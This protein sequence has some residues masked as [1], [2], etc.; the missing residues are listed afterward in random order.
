[1]RDHG[2]RMDLEEHTL[3]DNLEQTCSV[4]GARLTDAEIEA[5]R[6][7]GGPFLCSVHT[8]EALPVD[9]LGAEPVDE[10]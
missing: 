9:E 4:C 10:P 5:A 7:A 1:M 3:E 2:S 8:A 6:E